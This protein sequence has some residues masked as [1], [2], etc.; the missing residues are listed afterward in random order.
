MT[1][2]QQ[3]HGREQDLMS[4]FEDPNEDHLDGNQ[5]ALLDKTKTAFNELEK[6]T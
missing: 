3:T 4:Q 6:L 2:R 1:D 5:R